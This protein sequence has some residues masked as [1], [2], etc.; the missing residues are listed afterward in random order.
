MVVVEVVHM[1]GILDTVNMMDVTTGTP[2]NLD[3]TMAILRFR[4]EAIQ[5][6]CRHHHHPTTPLLLLITT[7]L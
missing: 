1:A 2:T 5:E 7:I 3:A 6:H 4:R